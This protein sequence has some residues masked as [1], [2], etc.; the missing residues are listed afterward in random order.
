MERS[1]NEEMVCA[2]NLIGKTRMTP[3]FFSQ[4]GSSIFPLYEDVITR[5]ETKL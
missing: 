3:L 4:Q 2:W 1:R 5:A